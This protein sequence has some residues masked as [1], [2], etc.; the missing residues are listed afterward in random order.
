MNQAMFTVE[1]LTPDQFRSVYPL[2]RQVAPGLTLHQWLRFARQAS[3]N[4]R[5]GGIVAIRRRTRAFPCGLFCY[6]VEQDLERGR[7]LVA[8]HFVALDLLDPQAVL[9]ALVTELEAL[10]NRLGCTA[11][12]SLVHQPEKQ[13]AGGLSAAGHSPDGEVLV[14][15]LHP[16]HAG[17]GHGPHCAAG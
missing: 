11:V 12:R 4:R 1:T 10:G 9:Q 5:G 14:K 13:V 15:D 2:I 17:A 6:R 16:P 8:E 3:S 7:V